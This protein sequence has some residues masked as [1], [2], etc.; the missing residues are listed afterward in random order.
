MEALTSADTSKKTGGGA[1]ESDWPEGLADLASMTLGA[2]ASGGQ[3]LHYHEDL[4]RKTLEIDGLRRTKNRLES[5]L[6]DLQMATVAIDMRAAEERHR[7]RDE[8][9]RLER[10][11]SRESAN[12]EY[13]KNVLLELFLRPDPSTQSHMFNAIATVLHFSPREVQRVRQQH[14]KWKSV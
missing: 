1:A 6:R 12:L 11:R 4:A 3:I 13:L 7:L 9:D 2:T 10:N 5:T 8:I 14:P